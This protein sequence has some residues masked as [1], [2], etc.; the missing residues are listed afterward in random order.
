MQV[1]NAYFSTLPERVYGITDDYAYAW[2]AG[3]YPTFGGGSCHIPFG[4]MFEVSDEMISSLLNRL[5]KPWMAEQPLPTFYD[6]ESELGGRFGQ[7]SPGGWNRGKLYAALRYARIARRFDDR[8]FAA[9]L[10]DSGAPSECNGLMDEF[11]RSEIG[12]Q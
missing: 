5:D 11:C 9:L 6:L 10:N 4:D 2:I 8:L 1:L 7:H 3:V 12:Y